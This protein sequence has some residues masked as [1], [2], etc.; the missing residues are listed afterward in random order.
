MLTGRC[1]L[2]GDLVDGE[3]DSIVAVLV[4][5]DEKP[6]RRIDAEVAWHQPECAI[7]VNASQSS[8]PPGVGNV[9]DQ[10]PEQ[11]PEGD[12]ECQYIGEQI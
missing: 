2:A 6:T 5:T 8:R 9:M 10:D 7:L 1:E 12:L 4:R 11:G 3:D